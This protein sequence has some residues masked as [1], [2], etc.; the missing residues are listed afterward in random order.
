MKRQSYFLDYLDPIQFPHLPGSTLFPDPCTFLDNLPTNSYSQL[1]NEETILITKM[2]II[3]YRLYDKH[4]WNE[5]G[6]FSD[7]FEL[8]RLPTLYPQYVFL[9]QIPF[10]LMIAWLKYHHDRRMDQTQ[11][12]GALLLLIDECKILIHSTTLIR[13]YVQTMIID[14]SEKS[15]LKLI[16][17]D[18]TQFDNKIVG[19]IQEILGYIERY[20]DISLRSNLFQNCMILLKD[21]WKSLK[22]YATMMNI[23]EDLGEQFLKMYSNIIKHFHDYIDVFHSKNNIDEIN[24]IKKKIHR[25]YQ[26]KLAMDLLREA[27]AIYEDCALTINIFLQKPVCQRFLLILKTAGFGMIKF[28]TDH[29]QSTIGSKTLPKDSTTQCVLFAPAEYFNDNQVKLQLIRT[30]SSSFRLNQTNSSTNDPVDE[31]TTAQQSPTSSSMQ[32]T[33]NEI[34]STSVYIL[35]VPISTELASKWRGVTHIIPMNKNLIPVSPL[36]STWKTTTIFLLTQQPENLLKFEELF[37]ERLSKTNVQQNDLYNFDTKSGQLLQKRSCF[38]NIDRAMNDLAH[39][40]LSLS[41]CVANNVEQFEKLI[42]TLSTT[43]NEQT[44]KFSPRNFIV[45]NSM[46]IILKGESFSVLAYRRTRIF[47]RHGS[48]S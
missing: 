13:Q 48:Y 9:V 7:K 18:L 14:V 21:Q 19:I 38:E 32:Q 31:Q 5:S 2:L 3:C 8:F 29:H 4:A 22:R 25:K 40:I 46:N 23:E 20:I 41:N 17:N 39:A 45:S 27:K 12:T 26:K 15:E 11:T 42:E 30:L 6:K 35:C 10:D 16:E 47:L 36:N 34:T 28:A 44:D 1:T 24:H 33:T 37:R 43:A